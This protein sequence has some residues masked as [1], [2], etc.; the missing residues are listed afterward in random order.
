VNEG[1]PKKDDIGCV[2]ARRA[3]ENGFTP[4]GVKSPP[5]SIGRDEIFTVGSSGAE[6]EAGRPSGR[7]TLQCCYV[8]QTASGQLF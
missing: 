4:G 2:F 5:Y 3:L 6:N 8:L 7:K 1:L